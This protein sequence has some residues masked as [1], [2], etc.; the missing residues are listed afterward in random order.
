MSGTT[1]DPA[2]VSAISPT[3]LSPCFARFSNRFGYRFICSCWCGPTTP[4]TNAVGLGSF[5]FARRYWGS[6]GFF[7]FLG[8][9]RC[10]SSPRALRAAYVFSHG[11]P[12]GGVS[13]FRHPR[14]VA[15]WAALRGLSQPCYVFHRLSAPYHPPHALSIFALIVQ[16]RL[17]PL[18][19]YSLFDCQRPRG[20]AAPCSSRGSRMEAKGFEPSTSCLQ[21][22]RS[23]N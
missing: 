12:F 1:R 11:S 9:L 4:T 7:L 5:P 13:S 23:P 3:G 15:C 2:Q 16:S 10:F 14:V 8:L 21:S 22:T 17:I 19:C 18:F 6:R 20:S